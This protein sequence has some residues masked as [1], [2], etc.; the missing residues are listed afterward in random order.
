MGKPYCPPV[1]LPNC[2]PGLTGPAVNIGVHGIMGFSY[3]FTYRSVNLSTRVDRS[4]CKYMGYK[5]L[6]VSRSCPPV[7]LSTCVPGLTGRQVNKYG[8]PIMYC[9]PRVPIC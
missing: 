9:S 3:L 7:D 8:I 2:L 5:A 4:R 6:W 1:D